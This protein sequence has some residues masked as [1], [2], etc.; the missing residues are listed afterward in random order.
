MFAE[1]HLERHFGNL[2]RNVL[3]GPETLPAYPRREV[4]NLLYGFQSE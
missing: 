4:L 1:S 3:T 2:E